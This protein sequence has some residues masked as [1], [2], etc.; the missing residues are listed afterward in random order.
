MNKLQYTYDASEVNR[1]LL[2]NDPKCTAACPQKAPVG[3]VLRSLYFENPIGAALKLGDTD[4]TYCNAPCERDCVLTKHKPAVEI[5]Q[6]FMSLKKDCEP[7]TGFRPEGVDVSTDIC[8]VKLENPFLLSSSVVASSY[9]MCRRAFEMGWAGASFKTI[10]SFPQHEASPR[11]SSIRNHAVSFCGFKN[12]EQLSDHSVRENM[13]IFKRLRKEFP[14]KVIVAS[15][16]GQ[17]E[18]EWTSLAAECE[19]AGASVIECNFSCPNMESDE[20]GIT[21]GQS[22]ELIER[23]TRATKKGTSL[24][25]LAKLTPNITDM[26]PM[27]IAAKR[28]GA[29]GIAAINTIN[30][31]TGVNLETL[32][33]EPAV[34]GKSIVGGYSGPA[35][36]P[37][38]LRFISDLA[39]SNDLKGMHISGMGGIETW[40]DAMEFMLL[41]ASSLQVTTSVM[42]Y[43][44]RI[45]DDLLEGIKVYMTRK[46]IKNL[47]SMI[48]AASASVVNHHG[49]ERDTIVFPIFNKERCNACGRCYIACMDGGHQAIRLDEET[50]F[51]RLD[52]T[53]CVG[54]HLCSLVCPLQCIEK[55]P[56]A[57]RRDH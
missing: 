40:S 53:R 41:G 14:T 25:V 12:I 31:I 46:G 18:E 10:C 47:K 57:I 34:R 39:N 27:A 37:I 6:V 32:T 36:K 42:Q 13:E 55:A 44:Y 24:P 38:A 26:V 49:I 2:C 15:I 43:G 3:T 51:P 52:G 30:S 20:L 23:F 8:G 11:F 50:G 56:K 4:C 17:N 33:A 9:D 1:C 28:G 45:I 7:V 21:I 22:E 54:C 29:D 48:G 5:R 19:K 16:M 35:V